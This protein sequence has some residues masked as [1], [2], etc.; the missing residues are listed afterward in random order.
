M[1]REGAIARVVVFG[2]ETLTCVDKNTRV[3]G[4][5]V[6]LCFPVDD[7]ICDLAHVQELLVLGK[8]T[9]ELLYPREKNR[10]DEKAHIPGLG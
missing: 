6:T 7:Q 2:W 3:F 10:V 9:F 1:E 8:L 4:K 5:R